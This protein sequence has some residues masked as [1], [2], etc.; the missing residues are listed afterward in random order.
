M[1]IYGSSEHGNMAGA[2]LN[3]FEML[4]N[5]MLSCSLTNRK[6]FLKNLSEYLIHEKLRN[7]E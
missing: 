3:S 6:T 4:E 5:Y 2:Y 7:S 1:A